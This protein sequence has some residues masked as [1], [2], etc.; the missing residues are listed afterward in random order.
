MILKSCTAPLNPAIYNNM[1]K[2]KRKDI[3][4]G[5][6]ALLSSID[7]DLTTI[8]RKEEVIKDLSNTIVSIPLRNITTN[9]YQPRKYFD[10]EAL[11]ELSESI[12]EYGLIQ[13]IT[14]RHMGGNDFQL[15]SGER[16]L[17]ASEMAGLEEIPAYVRLANDQKTLEMA[18]IE[19]VQRQQLNPLEIAFT[20]GRLMKEFNIT[21]EQLAER[22][23]KGRSSLSNYIR[24]MYLPDNIKNAL[25]KDLISMGHAKALLGACNHEVQL[26]AYK[27]IITESLSVRQTEALIKRYNSNELG[28]TKTEKKSKAKSSLSPA[29]RKVQTR[30]TSLFSAKVDLKANKAGKGQIVINFSDTEDLNRILDLF[31]ESE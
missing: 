16:R 14:V 8:E 28:H 15:I 12:Q 25:R 11:E 30:L 27:D 31:D 6:N 1:A 20:Y 24:L 19:N 21:Q 5:I 23:G 18:L 26:Q 22:L 4:K 13:P 2:R 10:P 29:Y 7:K 9:P 17:R 3:G